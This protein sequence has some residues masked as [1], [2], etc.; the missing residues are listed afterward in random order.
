MRLRDLCNGSMS[1]EFL[2]IQNRTAAMD[3]E[4]FICTLSKEKL[5][6]TEQAL[7][8]NLDPLKPLQVSSLVAPVTVCQLTQ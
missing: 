4:P 5:H 7:R 6:A 8:A 3:S 2:M 1:S